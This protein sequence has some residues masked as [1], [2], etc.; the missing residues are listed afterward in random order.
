MGRGIFRV[1]DDRIDFSFFACTKRWMETVLLK[2]GYH[3]GASDVYLMPGDIIPGEN[4]D[5]PRT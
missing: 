3:K 1:F 4:D 2:R 5:Y